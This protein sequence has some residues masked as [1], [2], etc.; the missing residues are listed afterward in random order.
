MCNKR[1]QLLVLMC[2]LWI[3]KVW[4]Q[5]VDLALGLLLGALGV[6]A[7]QRLQQGVASGALGQAVG[8][9]H[10]GVQL[11]VQLAQH[12]YQALGVDGLFLGRQG[13]ALTQGGQHVVQ[14]GEGQAGRGIHSLAR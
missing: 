3:L 13:A 2:F 7:H 12:P 8:G 9:Q 4:A 6:Q 1:W 5:P 10:G 14:A 11:V